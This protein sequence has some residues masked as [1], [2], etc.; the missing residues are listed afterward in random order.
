MIRKK[1]KKWYKKHL[2]QNVT[3][4]VTLLRD[5]GTEKLI[6]SKVDFILLYFYFRISNFIQ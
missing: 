3:L 1:A 6:N 2:F 4:S 5:F